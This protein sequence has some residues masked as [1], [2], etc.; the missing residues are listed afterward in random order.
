[1]TH[2]NAAESEFRR[3][4]EKIFEIDNNDEFN[5]IAHHTF[6]LQYYHNPTF[7]AYC[8]YLGKNPQNCNDLKTLPFL[9]I[10]F[11]KSKEVLTGNS[12]YEIFFESSGTTGMKR[13]RHFLKKKKL[14]QESY[15]KGFNIFY[16]KP[17]EYCILALLPGYIENKHS[18]LITMVDGLIKQSNCPESGFYLSSFKELAERL[19]QLDKKGKKVL[20]LGVSFALLDMAE[21]YPLQLNNTIIMETGGMKGRRKEIT[22]EELHGRLKQ[23]FNVEKIHSEYGMAE[24]LSQAYSTGNGKFQTPPWMKVMARDAYDPFE[25][26]DGGEK[27]PL[28]GAINVIDL[29][30]LYSCSFIE[31]KDIGKLYPDK[32]FEVL[33]RLDYSDIRGC[34]LMVM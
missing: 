22:R 4:E 33:G 19:S 9:P 6:Y 8:D 21:K 11:F 20:L 29:A 32:T 30:N 28:S 34:N 1:M 2:A 3:L 23:A 24:L 31:T 15:N 25:I 7:K 17:E 13:S 27:E 10:D 18:S 26:L 12:N 16:G 14:Y 5:S